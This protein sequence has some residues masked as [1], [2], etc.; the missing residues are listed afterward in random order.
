MTGF[1]ALFA[2][3]ALLLGL[4]VANVTSSF[5]DMYRSRRHVRIG[6]TTPLLGVVIL[7]SVCHQWLAVFNAQELTLRAGE[8]IAMLTLALPY[9]FISQA[10]T[11]RPGEAASLEEHYAGHR[12]VLA[13]M[14]LVPLL[15]SLVVNVVYLTVEH[16][17]SGEE[18]IGLIL[19][20]GFRCAFVAAMLIWSAT[21][22]Q[23]AGLSA[24]GAYTLL[25]MI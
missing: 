6:W 7:L 8:I 14:L 11:P 17:W 16:K 9:I 20:I 4:A 18:A 1:E 22:V 15:T 12:L 25:L 5:A 24:L 3:Y 19:Y 2:F 21:W 10:M 23:R 13:G